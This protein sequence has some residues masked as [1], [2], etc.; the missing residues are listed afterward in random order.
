ML[1]LDDLRSL[2]SPA[3]LADLYHLLGYPVDQEA[4]AYTPDDIGIEG[5]AAND[6]RR[7]WLLVDLGEGSDGLQHVHFEVTDL[8]AAT[9]RRVTEGF[10]KRPG[11]YLL[12]FATTQSDFERLVFVKPRRDGGSVKLGR[13]SVQP[14]RPTAHDLSLL[15]EVARPAGQRAQ[16]AH[17]AQVKAFN[18]ERVTKRFY[19]DY[20]RLFEHV[21]GVIRDEN[22]N[23]QLGPLE[24]NRPEDR[25]SLHAFT[26]RLLGRIIFL[27]FIQKKGWLDEAPD[28]IADLYGKASAH[29]GGNFY[30]D[31][32]EP[33]F[34]NVLNTPRPSNA[35][36]LGRIPYLN[37]SLFERE[38]PQDTV[39]NL[40]NSL[41]D[42][43]VTGSILHTLGGYNFTI[44]ES[45]ALEQDVSLDPE[46]LGKVFENMMEEEEAA[47][48]GTFYTPRSIVQFM[49]EETLTRYLADTTG[50]GQERLLLLVADDS[51]VHDL[52]APEANAIIEAL[53]KVRVLDP[54]VGTASMLVGFLSAMIRVRRSAEARRGVN[55]TEGSPAL[56][57]WKREY[58]QHC[59]YGVDIKQEAIEIAR[60]RLWLSLVVDAQ[61]PEPLPNLEYKLMAGDGLL[62]TVDGTPF[63]KVEQ[64]IL[65]DQALVTEKAQAIETKHEAFFAEQHP[66]RRRALRQEIQQ[67]ERE[68]FRADVDARIKGLDGQ[69]RILDGQIAHPTL[70]ERSRATL[71]KRRTALAEN[72]G[73]LIEQKIKVWD[74]KEPLPFFLHNVHF[75]E[76]MKDDNRGGNGGFDIVIGNPPYVRTQRLAKN[77]KEALQ[78]A[79]SEVASGTADLYVYFYQ[80]GLNVLREGGRLAYITP[81]KFMRAGYGEKLRGVLSSKTRVEILA[82]FGDLPIF[83]AVVLTSIVMVQKAKP[84]GESI[85]MLPERTLKAKLSENLTEGVD[86]FREGMASFHSFAREVMAALNPNVL[87]TQEWTLD[88]PGVLRLIAKLKS[89]GQP[90]GEIVSGQFSHG[91]QTSLNQ[92]FIIDNEAAQAFISEDPKNCDIIKPYLRGKDIERWRINEREKKYIILLRNTGD[93]ALGHPWSSE[94]SES[95]A[96]SIFESEYPAIYRYMKLNEQELR[97][98]TEKGRFWWELRS[99]GYYSEFKKSKI[100]YPDMGRLPRFLWDESGVYLGNTTYFIC[101]TDRWLVPILNSRMTEYFMNSISPTIMGGSRRYFSQYLEQLPIVTP[102]PTQAA[103]LETFTDDSRLPELNALV[104]EMYCLTPAEIELVESLTAGAYAGAGDAA[105]ELEVDAVGA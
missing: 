103:M 43:R 48:S 102:T 15:R 36:D 40:P 65:G 82:D 51:A 41:F 66:E 17:L 79:F 46:M 25:A 33:L 87:T 20:R 104:Y 57:S 2:R 69:I 74:E 97:D 29:P 38:Y 81:N 10:L 30:R 89:Q 7:V 84:D 77:Y 75:A 90:L 16:A 1:H 52:S 37:G 44:A 14:A 54:A 60:L 9:L 86:S 19:D 55:V 68:L 93:K 85:R 8:H 70:A 35:S 12:T 50:I 22:P 53:G 61:E 83:D 64:A 100:V 49:V 59:L 92:V 4:P 67:L 101:S 5:A 72:M 27:Y 94:R 63:I 105:E 71:A 13:L 6:V 62:E 31:G 39:L 96:E 45:G 76:V 34:F 99:C 88:E 47:Q 18:V 80:K 58:I 42:P 26:Q 11:E 98:R 78:T 95:I 24:R 3:A 23:A 91:I 28:F 21:R 56:A 32:L 73:R